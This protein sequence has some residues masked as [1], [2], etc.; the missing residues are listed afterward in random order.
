MWR[1]ACAREPQSNKPRV[2][3]STT[4]DAAEGVRS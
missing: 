2:R 4:A 3:N 1:H